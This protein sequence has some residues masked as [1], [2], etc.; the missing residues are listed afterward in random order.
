MHIGYARV[1]TEEQ[2]VDLQMDALKSAGCERIF[3]DTASGTRDDRPGLREALEFVRPGDTLI[4]W[5]LDRL[6]RS[7]RQLVGLVAEL[8]DRGI[9]FKSLQEGFDTG[10]SGGKLIFHVFS[11]MAELERDVLRERTCAGLAAAKARGRLGGRPKKLQAHQI[12]MAKTL[13][14]DGTSKFSDVCRTLGVSRSTLYRSLGEGTNHK[15]RHSCR[16]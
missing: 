3:T 1:S 15:E 8:R 5:R 4:S 7:V 9:G 10:S 6:G 2:R 13:V 16:R 11:A 12:A 14:A